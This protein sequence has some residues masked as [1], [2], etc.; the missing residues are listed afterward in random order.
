MKSL[1]T[2]VKIRRT[3]KHDS[4]LLY[5]ALVHEHTPWR[6]KLAIVWL[7]LYTLAP[8]DLI[9]DW[10]LAFGIIDDIAVIIYVVGIIK[11]NIPPKVKGEIE[12]NIIDVSH[13]KRK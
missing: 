12:G 1:F 5:Q 9:P 2:L 6:I 3:I 8:F 11:K 13:E 10:V 7:I 4:I